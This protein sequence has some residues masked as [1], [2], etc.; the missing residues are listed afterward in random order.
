[1][2]MACLL[3]ETWEIVVIQTTAVFHN[4]NLGDMKF[5]N[6]LEIDRQPHFRRLRLLN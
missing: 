6:Y 3:L 4:G 2:Y 5:L 1:M